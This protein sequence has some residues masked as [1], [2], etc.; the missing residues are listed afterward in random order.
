VLR[1]VGWLGWLIVGYLL[2]AAVYELTLALRH[3]ISPDGEWQIAGVAVLA[4]L[5][6][7][8]LLFRIFRFR[9]PG[10][11]APA[12]A[13]FV[14]ARFY[15][16]DP[17]YEPYFRAYGDGGL[18]SLGWVFGLLALALVAGIATQRWRRTAPWESAGV[19]LLLA[20]TATFMSAGH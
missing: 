18:F 20:F 15:T 14:V 4:M 11:F 7:A 9:L 5:A 6:G 10:L 1:A 19:L 3:S 13:F 16:G 8:V 12:A 2:G 17:Y